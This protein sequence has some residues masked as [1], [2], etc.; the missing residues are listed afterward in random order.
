MNFI[1]TLPAA[2]ASI[3]LGAHFLRAGNS[4]VVLYCVALL[5]FCFIRR[6]SFRAVVRGSLA[7]GVIVWLVTA[8]QIVAAKS[9]AGLPAGRSLVI[10]LGVATFTAVALWLLPPIEGDEP[11]EPSSEKEPA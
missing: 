7:L 9:G 11:A 8:M 4:V 1:K 6:P 5:I 10:L 3:L 2:L